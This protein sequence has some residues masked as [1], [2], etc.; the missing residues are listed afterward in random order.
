M[1]VTS[2]IHFWANKLKYSE[3]NFEASKHNYR[4]ELKEITNLR[5]QVKAAGRT[6]SRYQKLLVYGKLPLDKQKEAQRRREKAADMLK[7]LKGSLL[8]AEQRARAAKRAMSQYIEEVHKAKRFLAKYPK[9][10]IGR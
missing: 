10:R 9:R 6:W 2:D 5:G 4:L 1:S 3:R 8:M 7:N